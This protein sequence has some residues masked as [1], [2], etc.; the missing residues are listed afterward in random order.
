MATV[1]ITVSGMS[2]EALRP[3]PITIAADAVMSAASN[4]MPGRKRRAQP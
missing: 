1:N 4:C 3:K 2:V